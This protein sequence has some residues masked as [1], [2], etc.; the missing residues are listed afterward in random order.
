LRPSG[1][2]FAVLV[3]ACVSFLTAAV[4]TAN[5]K[6]VPQPILDALSRGEPQDLIVEFDGRAILRRAEA[7]RVARAVPAGDAEILR[8]MAREFASL[9]ASALSSL[10]PEEYEVLRHYS[11]LPMVFLRVRSRRALEQ[12]LERPDIVRAYRD[13]PLKKL[14]AQSLPLI[15]QPQA[16]AAGHRGVG[17]TVAVLDGGADYTRSAFGS[18]T[19]PGVPAGCKV[20][21]HQEFADPD[22]TLDDPDLHG[23]NVSGIV[24]GVA[25]DSRI[26][27]LDVFNVDETNDSIVLEGVNW[28][29][30]NKAQ[31]NIVAMNLSLGGESGSP[32]PCTV[33]SFTPAFGLARSVGIL[34]VV[35]SGNSA[36]TNQLSSPACTPGAVS[37]GAVYDS[38]VGPVTYEEPNACSDPTT[39]ADQVACFSNSADFL[40]L[41]AP[42][43]FITAA[44]V[45]WQGTS[46]AAPHV[47]GAVAVLRSSH[48]TEVLEQTIARLT[49]T[50]A[51]VTDSR[52]GLTKPRI[53]LG[54]AAAAPTPPAP[55]PPPTCTV[56]PISCPVTLAGSLSASDC[57]GGHLGQ[58][59]FTDVYEF[60]GIAGQTVTIEMSS[61]AAPDFDSFL[62]LI[63]PSGAFAAYNDDIDLGVNVNSRLV[64]T[65][66]ATGTWRVEASTFLPGTTGDYSLSISGCSPPMPSICI[67]G[68]N[69]LCLS[70]GRFQVQTNWKKADGTTGAG[71]AFGLTA[72]TGYFWFFDSTNVEMVVKVL[73]ACSF[74]QR[75]WVFA[76]GLTNV[77][78]TMVVTDTSNGIFK[79]Y[80]NPQGTAYLPIQDTQAFATCSSGSV[81]LAQSQAVGS[82]R[83][84]DPPPGI[85]AVKRSLAK[86][87]ARKVSAA[88]CTPGPNALC[89]SGGR[90]RVQATW[91]RPDGTSGAGNAVS[92]T[93]DTGYFWFFDS[94]NVEIVV[95]VLNACG[96][97]QRI[98]VFSGGLTNVEVTMTVED[99]VSGIV[100]TYVNPQGTAFVP[101]QDTSAFA[102][103]P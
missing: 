69:T 43:V 73:D 85:F 46:Q 26:A 77:E 41:L 67:P 74:A 8:G 48:P 52:N 1:K 36:L 63:S 15:R 102:D 5:T 95:K 88:A 14:L 47:S 25:P 29:I 32:G 12:L 76:G 55:P 59:Y 10:K 54:A 100:K 81:S 24:L 83:G 7:L 20:V 34:P 19:S 44:G 57:T 72:D 97:A 68:P 42:G 38:D 2:P 51:P 80:V 45:T 18:C 78:V 98:W 60:S 65:L 11:H 99:T 37:V 23:T 75:L 49:T 94:T 21:A 13:E 82:G 79:T 40:T 91:R 62:V 17:T 22:G 71:N 30:A 53:N 28:S 39:A 6:F 96:F 35:A 58:T 4:A 92:L 31:Y 9:K 103:C 50:G 3:A 87:L 16:A 89:L 56:Q 101:I 66:N 90:F 70:G 33:S 27:A 61:P 64:F 93:A 84:S 86:D